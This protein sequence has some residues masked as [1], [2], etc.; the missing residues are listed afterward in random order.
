MRTVVIS[1]IGVVSVLIVVMTHTAVSEQSIHEEEL[2][3]ALSTAMNQTMEEVFEQNSYGIENHNEMIAAFL[4]A[5]ICKVNPEISL[6]VRVYTCD[7]ENGILDVEASGE[8]NIPETGKRKVSV[9][10][11]MKYTKSTEEGKKFE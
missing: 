11:K 10:R 7:K 6:T 8:Y 9:R 1:V 2:Q 4:Q 5:M 3:T